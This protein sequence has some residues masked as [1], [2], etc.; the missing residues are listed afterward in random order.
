MNDTVDLLQIKIEKAKRDL[1][2]ATINAINSVDWKSALLALREKKG[3]TFEQ[4]GDLELE[5][6][7]LL[8]G[9]VSPEDYPKELEK[10]LRLSGSATNELVNEMN[11]LVFNRIREEMIKNIEKKRTFQDNN[12]AGAVESN[13]TEILK[14]AGIEIIPEKLEL[15]T[16][17]TIIPAPKVAIPTPPRPEAV[18][19]QTMLAQK[20]AGSVKIP[21]AKT[22]YSL[23]N[24]S[25]ASTPVAPSVKPKVLNADPYREIPE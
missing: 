15:N 14:S 24:I 21:A 5:T 11:S 6:E 25:K 22:E 8:C 7:L 4:L 1:P 12:G 16:G 13:D 3:Y 23:N 2:L 17:A 19:M 9:L 10:R 20:I 18:N